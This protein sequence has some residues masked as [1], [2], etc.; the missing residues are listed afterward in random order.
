MDVPVPFIG[1]TYADNF[2]P[3]DAQRCVNW[4]PQNGALISRPGHETWTTVGNGPIRQWIIHKDKLVVV[5]GAGVYTVNENGGTSYVGSVGT[6]LGPA[7]MASS[8]YDGGEVVIADGESISIC[9]GGKIGRLSIC[10]N[11]HI[12]EI[13][14]KTPFH[15]SASRRT[16]RLTAAL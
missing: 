2:L 3:A 11:A 12:T 9:P 15:E 7:W 14:T 8:G 4:V 6:D 13:V 10:V 16:E 1:P 5:S